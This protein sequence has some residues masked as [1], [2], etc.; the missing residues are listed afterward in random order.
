ME[1][2]PAEIFLDGV[3]ARHRLIVTGYY[4]D[5]TERDL[6]RDSQFSVQSPAVATFSDQ[7]VVTALHKGV[8]PITVRFNE[9][10]ATAH[11]HVSDDQRTSEVSFSRDILPILTLKGCNS[12]NC[13]GSMHGKNGFK[14]SLFGYEAQKDYRM[15]AEAALARRVNRVDPAASLLLLKPTRSIRHGGGKRFAVES[16]EYKTILAWITQGAPGADVAAGPQIDRLKVLPGMRV[17]ASSGT[18]QQ[19]IVTAHYSDGTVEDVTTKVKYVPQDESILAV[20]ENGLVEAK[21]AGESTILIRGMGSVG[22]ARF[23]VLAGPPLPN[24]PNF[25]R[26]NF[27]DDWVSSKLRRLN[28]VPSRL[29]S[30]QVFVRRAYLDA[31][32]TLPTA[33]EVRTFFSDRD[34]QKRRKLIDH[35][36]E[37][38][39]YGD[40]WGLLWADFFTVTGFKNGFRTL[41]VDQWLRQQLRQNAPFDKMVREVVSESGATA[42]GPKFVASRTAEDLASFYS[43]LFLGVRIQCAQCHDH[44]FEKW[45]RNDYYGVVAFLG[46]VENPVTRAPALPKFLGGDALQPEPNEDG[47][48]V[49]ERK[50]ILADWIT[51][52]SN[53]FFAAAI[54][55]RIWRHFMG[56][57]L[58]EPA[59]DFRETNPPTNP[60]LLDALGKEFVETGYDLRH[61]MKLIMNSRTYQLSSV[62]EES[63]QSDKKNYS[64]YSMRRIYAEPLLD[65]VVQ[66]TGAPHAFRFGYHGMKAVEL[67]ESQI[68][69]GFLSTFD[70]NSRDRTCEREENITLLQSLALISG[71]AVNEKIRRPGGT[72]DHLTSAR[73]SN[74]EII[75]ELFLC[76][77][78]RY[79]TGEEVNGVLSAIENSKIRAHG[80]QDLLWALINSKEFLFIH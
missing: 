3:G 20:D 8:T 56:V 29:C 68:P 5:G 72:I 58:V 1:V 57:G 51:S 54:S 30:D 48:Q 18:H 10:E 21:K 39:E 63:N 22:V 79:P 41:Y 24:Y 52:P 55:N 19:L 14:L 16:P 62:T 4:A 26:N 71:E 31:I 34:P 66:V 61:L 33:E 69:D 77:V 53:P 43:Q 17:L 70:R 75:E 64:H 40:Y 80:L 7:G 67:H 38:P 44:P 73:L 76:T 28:L 49:A 15:L 78:S 32:G 23:A 47:P 65:A 37:R 50:K 36:L 74:S 46:D 12:A 45:T 11:V 60:E 27:I 9:Q 6:T 42:R 13:H 25:P 59:D 2:Q 35:V